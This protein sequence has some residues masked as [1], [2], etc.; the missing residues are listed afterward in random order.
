MFDSYVYYNGRTIIEFDSET[1]IIVVEQAIGDT[2]RNKFDISYMRP[3]PNFGTII[4]YADFLDYTYSIEPAKNIAVVNSKSYK[5]QPFKFS[6]KRN[7]E[8][9]PKIEP[10]AEPATK[11]A[12]KVSDLSLLKTTPLPPPKEKAISQ[13]LVDAATKELKTAFDEL[14]RTQSIDGLIDA[15]EVDKQKTTFRGAGLNTV[16]FDKLADEYFNLYSDIKQGNEK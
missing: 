9:M 7:K 8:T 1:K 14:D 3:Y 12:F 4:P 13:D 11:K 15:Q 2:T 16:E 5:I 10:E 6:L